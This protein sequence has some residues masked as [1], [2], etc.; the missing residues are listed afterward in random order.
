MQVVDHLDQEEKLEKE[1]LVLDVH[2]DNISNQLLR[3][4]Q[5]C[6]AVKSPV[7]SY[8]EPAF[9]QCLTTPF[10]I[11]RKGLGTLLVPL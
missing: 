7:D 2:N 6:D 11:E 8:K 1:Q 10:F 3:L 4:Q 9:S 5:L